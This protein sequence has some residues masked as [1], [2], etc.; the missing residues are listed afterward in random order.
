MLALPGLLASCDALS[1]SASVFRESFS[2]FRTNRL[3]ITA[4][5]Q[6]NQIE[7]PRETM[8][9]PIGGQMMTFKKSPE[10]SQRSISGFEPFKAEKEEDGY[11]VLL[12]LDS[13]GRNSLDLAS[14]EY[15]GSVLLTM[16]N[17]TPVDMVELDEPI[18]DGRF[19]IWRG[20]TKKTIDEMD[21]FYPRIKYMKSSSRMMDDMMPSTDKEKLNSRREAMALEAAEKAAARQKERDLQSGKVRTLPKRK[22]IIPLEDLKLPG[23]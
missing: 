19:T 3:L 12:Q 23:T 18:T 8:K 2:A 13:K 7:H 5:V 1:N 4:H 17:A 15:H 9:L 10:F 11:G 20:L 16:V 21:K 6:S 14:R 22:D